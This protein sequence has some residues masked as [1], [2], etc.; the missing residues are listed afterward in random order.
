MMN[1]FFCPD[2]QLLM[3]Q[4]NKFI[5]VTIV[6]PTCPSHLKQAQTQL[7]VAHDA[8][9]FK[10]NKYNKLSQQHQ[11]EFI[12]FAVESFRGISESALKLIQEIAIFATDHLSAWSKEEII[13]NLNSSIACA[14]QRGNA[15]ITALSGYQASAAA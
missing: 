4:Y 14:I 13:E 8:C 12:P 2:L 1:E 11:A 5:D 6:H 15:A 3:D 9:E 7:K 10:K